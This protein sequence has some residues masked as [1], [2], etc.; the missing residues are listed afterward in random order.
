M[1][2][3]TKE[4]ESPVTEIASQTAES[5]VRTN[6]WNLYGKRGDHP[7]SLNTNW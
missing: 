2:R 5:R 4:G 1:G 7:P 3:S 6:T